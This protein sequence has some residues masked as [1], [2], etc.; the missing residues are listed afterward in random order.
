V[1]LERLLASLAN[2]QLVDDITEQ[3]DSF[4][5]PESDQNLQHA[6]IFFYLMTENEAI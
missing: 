2:W 5:I 3:L 6:M 1:F 4:E